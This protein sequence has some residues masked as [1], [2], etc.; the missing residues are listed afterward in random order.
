MYCHKNA[1][2]QLF[3]KSNKFKFIH[4]RKGLNLKECFI[5]FVCEIKPKP[6]T[7]TSSTLI[8]IVLLI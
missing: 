6:V 7:K 3:V 8:T 2:K 5:R 4:S 1:F